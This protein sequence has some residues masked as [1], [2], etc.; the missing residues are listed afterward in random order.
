MKLAVLLTI[1]SFAVAVFSAAQMARHFAAES[2]VW[3]GYWLVLLVWNLWNLRQC[4]TWLYEEIAWR[5][6]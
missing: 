3:G 5:H 4:L 2:Y 1:V 6:R